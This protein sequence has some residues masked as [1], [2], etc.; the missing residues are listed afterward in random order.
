[1]SPDPLPP[2]RDAALLLD[3]DGTLLDLAPRPDDVVVPPGLICSLRAI[4][5]QLREALA[6]VTGRPIETIDALLGDAP[7]AVAGEHGGAVRPMPGAVIERSDLPSPPRSWIAA[8]AALEA[9]Y[10][11]AMLEQKPRGFALH[12]RLAPD[13]GAAIQAALAELLARSRDFELMQGHMLWEIRPRGVDKGRAVAHLMRSAPFHG[14]VPVFI[15]DDVTDED[16]MRVAR[17]LGGA[18][19]RVADVFG[20]PAGVRDWLRRTASAAEWG[21]F[22]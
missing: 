22:P 2:Y 15:G 12:Y 17:G 20:D 11:G 5:G 14:R 3:L 16:G 9:A 10:P 7:H 21:A 19:L 4:R 13:A 18:G 1:M 6:V 8:G